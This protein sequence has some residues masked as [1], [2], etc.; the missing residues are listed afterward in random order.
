VPDIAWPSGLDPLAP[1]R[2]LSEPE[3]IALF[4]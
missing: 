4:S 2:A 3:R 1:L